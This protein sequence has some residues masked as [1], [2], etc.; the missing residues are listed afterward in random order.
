MTFHVREI[1]WEGGKPESNTMLPM[2]HER[3]SDA[4][5]YI[6]SR[7]R[8]YEKKGY[9]EKADEWWA[10]VTASGVVRWTIEEDDNE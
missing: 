3:W 7:Q 2:V 4:V 6:R 1:I 8:S 10:L 9:D 5:D